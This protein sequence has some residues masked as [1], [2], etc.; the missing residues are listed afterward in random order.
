MTLLVTREFSQWVVADGVSESEF[1]VRCLRSTV[2]GRRRE[3]ENPS[4]T[5]FVTFVADLSPCGT[6]SRE[7]RDT[8]NMVWRVR[9]WRMVNQLCRRRYMNFCGAEVLN[10]CTEE[11]RGDRRVHQA[12]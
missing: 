8:E 10:F 3:A 4:I 6:S 12:R 1:E 2:L 9:L 11:S 7:K 5:W